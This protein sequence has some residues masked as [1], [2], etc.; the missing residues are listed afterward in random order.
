MMTA[1]GKGKWE[2]MEEAKRGI[3]GGGKRL[4]FGKSYILYDFN[5]MTFQQRQNFV[6]E[7]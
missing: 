2:E 1:R 5:Y 3:N 4:D 7:M 6:D